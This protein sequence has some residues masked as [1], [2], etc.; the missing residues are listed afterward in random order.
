MTSLEVLISDLTSKKLAAVE[1]EDYTAA[2]DYK[3]E[4][5]NISKNEALIR[6]LFN[7]KAEALSSEDYLTAE[8]IVQKI[9]DLITP[10]QSKFISPPINI[11]YSPPPEVVDRPLPGPDLN[12]PPDSDSDSLPEHPANSESSK[13][14]FLTESSAQPPIAPPPFARKGPKSPRIIHKKVDPP[15]SNESKPLNR[16]KKQRAQ[17]IGRKR[18]DFSSEPPKENVDT[19]SDAHR[20]EAEFLIN[21]FGESPVAEAYSSGWSHKVNGYKRLCELIK[22]LKSSSDKTKAFKSLAPLTRERFKSGLK[23]V[24][25]SS[26]EDTISLIDSIELPSVE[27]SSFVHQFLP[28]MLTKMSDTNPRISEAANRFVLWSIDKEKSALNEVSQFAVKPPNASNQYLALSAKLSLLKVLIEKHGLGKQ[29]K[30][31]DVMKLA[32][33]CLES[34][35]AEVRQQAFELL[36]QVHAIVGSVVDKYLISAPRILKEQLKAA[37]AK[38][39]EGK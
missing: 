7:Q 2:A 15:P 6:N 20:S 25:C 35:K 22:G 32:V 19:L 18:V 31:P 12:P 27:L 29:I 9:L 37:F 36:I 38:E 28:L 21:L 16:P 30:T 13:S 8:S 3:T 26:I 24:F 4:L 34:R 23:A 11:N 1:I 17:H 5:D 10:S 39:N 14:V 33:T